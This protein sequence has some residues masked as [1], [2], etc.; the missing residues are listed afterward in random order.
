VPC[1]GDGEVAVEDVS[2]G[3][4]TATDPEAFAE[5]A[6]VK[7][8]DATEERLGRGSDEVGLPRVRVAGG[9][10]LVFEAGVQFVELRADV[11]GEGEAVFGFDL[12]PDRI[13][14]RTPE[15]PRSRRPHSSGVELRA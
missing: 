9:K 12:R 11:L 2:H 14:A 4:D 13:R 6:G 10:D 1:A 5:V 7:E 8:I 15:C 3:D